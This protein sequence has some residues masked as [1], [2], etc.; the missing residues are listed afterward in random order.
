MPMW[1]KEEVDEI[2]IAQV[3]KLLFNFVL[4]QDQI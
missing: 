3:N 4:N 1:D 2:V